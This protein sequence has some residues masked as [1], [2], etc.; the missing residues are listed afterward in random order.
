MLS[1]ELLRL[2]Q[3]AESSKDALEQASLLKKVEVGKKQLTTASSRKDGGGSRLKQLLHKLEA[4]DLK[5]DLTTDGCGGGC[6]SEA[7]VAGSGPRPAQGLL[8]SSGTAGKEPCST[9]VLR[10][11][12]KQQQE[13]AGGGLWSSA[14]SAC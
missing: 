1:G 12:L 13:V 7:D 14:S 9:E 2:Q 10:Q 4:V 8:C 11:R 3:S 6:E 5:P